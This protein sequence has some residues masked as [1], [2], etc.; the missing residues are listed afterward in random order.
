M[1]PTTLDRLRLALSA[2]K[3][4]LVDRGVLVDLILLAAVAGEHALVIGPPGTAKSQAVRRIAASLG[5]RYFEYLL[6]RFT[7]PNE[8]FGPVD[9]SR[10]REGVVE[11][12]TT[13]MLPEAEIAFLDEVFQGSS[14]ILNT[15]LGILQERRFRRG[16]TTMDCPLRICVAASNQL[17]DDPA[18]D[19]F[20]DRFLLRIFVDRVEDP[21]L[22]ELLE[23][24]WQSRDRLEAVAG[25]ADLAAVGAAAAAVDLTTV[26]PLLA[27]A[28]RQLRG[29]G[30]R[31][32]DR[33]AVKCQSLIAAA[34]ALDGRNTATPSD[35][36]PIL[37]AIPTREQQSL[38]QDLLRE[39]LHHSDS[40]TLPAAA[41]EA[42]A[43]PLTKARRIADCGVALLANK[44]S[45]DGAM[46]RLQLEGV[47]R[48]IDA[49]FPAAGLPDGL[50]SVRSR[51]VEELAKP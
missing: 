11:T 45:S 35:L 1:L 31:L 24:G 48:E 13:G 47:A 8:V 19:A 36:W 29:A 30:I 42:S 51:I 4:G 10:L 23:S 12:L 16:L 43:G 26:R 3:D 33:R 49:S 22:E 40:A 17:A 20:A 27:S 46:W 37:Y 50:V 5:G 14:A 44:P 18:L 38:A 28:L 7:E 41:E 32:S 39:A 6:G 15:L 25:I 9:L 2:A 34:A 21:R